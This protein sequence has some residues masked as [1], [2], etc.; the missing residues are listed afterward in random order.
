MVLVG[1]TGGWTEAKREGKDR[2]A[3]KAEVIHKIKSG[4]K[5]RTCRED[6]PH[7]R[8]VKV[9]STLNLYWG[10]RQRD[11]EHI[12]NLELKRKYPMSIIG[13]K[14]LGIVSTI[15]QIVISNGGTRTLSPEEA[16]VFARGDGFKDF[17]HMCSYFKKDKIYTVLEWR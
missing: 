11:C 16:D 9:D 3:Q 1:F 14:N 6:S 5:I 17:E 7:W 4:V 12:C 13:G 2:V 8:K 10:T 15:P